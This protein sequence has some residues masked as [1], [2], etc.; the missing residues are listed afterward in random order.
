LPESPVDEVTFKNVVSPK[1]QRITL[2]DV[3]KFTFE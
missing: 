3:G 2:Q 1:C